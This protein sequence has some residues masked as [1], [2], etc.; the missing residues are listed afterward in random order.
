MYLLRQSVWAILLQMTDTFEIYNAWPGQHFIAVR[1]VVH[2]PAYA[3]LI[4]HQLHGT[5]QK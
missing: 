2:I 4:T 5:T 1:I 3:R